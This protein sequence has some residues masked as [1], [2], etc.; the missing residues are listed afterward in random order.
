MVAVERL[1]RRPIEIGI[2]H[3][4][5][6]HARVDSSA[7]RERAVGVER[8]APAANEK[9]IDQRIGGPRVEGE[10]L[11]SDGRAR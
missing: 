7:G 8:D 6:E 3:H 5:F 11:A 1:R 9:I 10:D 2:A 4:R